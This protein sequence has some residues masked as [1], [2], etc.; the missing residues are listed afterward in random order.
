MQ[1]SQL[2]GRWYPG[3][4]ERLAG[5]VD[6]YLTAADAEPDPALRAVI[7]PHA[8]Y[9]YSG[10][11]A[12]AA[13][14]R[15]PR[16]RW[17]RAA[18]LAPSHFR[19]FSGAA[20]HPGEGFETPLG[21]VPVDREAA[22]HLTGFPGFHGDPAP[23]RGEHSLEIELPF[24]QR[25]DPELAIV[26]VL[27]GAGEGSFAELAPGLRALADDETLFVV[28]SDFTHYGKAFDYL[29][30]PPSGAGEVA[31]G[32]RELDRG[33]IEAVCRLAP[34]E[35]TAYVRRTGITICGRAPITAFLHSFR[36]SRLA[37]A[38]V[39]YYTSLGV[40]GDYEHSVSYAAIVFAPSGAGA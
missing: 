39:S 20:V 1:R 37:G 34:E 10:R 35:L 3:D 16:G 17:R 8:G 13:F 6:A 21:I 14:A 28:S 26:P 11:A 18:V 30:F 12:G 27:V 22:G 9:E 24:L 19:L 4:P 40:T 15:I 5:V 32:L 31:E 2:A 23:Y 29:P 33:A 25:V 7:V 38:L 36:D